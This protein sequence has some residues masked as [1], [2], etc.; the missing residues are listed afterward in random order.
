MKALLTVFAA[1][2]GLLVLGCTQAPS[3]TEVPLSELSGSSSLAQATVF[4]EKFDI[5]VDETVFSDCAGEDIRFTGAV[6]GEA[7]T[8]VD[9]NGRLHSQ[10]TLNDHDVS[11][12]GLLSGT[13]YHRVGATN[14]TFNASGPPPLEVTVTNSFNFIGQGAANNTLLIET[15]HFTVNANGEVTAT[16]GNFSFECK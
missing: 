13:E 6:H 8:V 1:I 7:H 9:A 4:H 2:F 11:G 15:F 10:S 12:V 14:S 3:P 5:P 16:V